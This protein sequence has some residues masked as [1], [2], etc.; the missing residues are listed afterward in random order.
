MAQTVC[1]DT[2]IVIWGILGE[3]KAEDELKREKAVHL[4]EML[5]QRDDRVLL[6][7][8]VLAEVVAKVSPPD[9]EEVV[10]K[11]S[12]AC[13]IVPFDAGSAL[14]FGT[15]RAVGMKKKSREF[16]RKEI[17]LD[18]LIVAICRRQAVQVLYTDDG[19]L[20]KLAAH[21]M[22]VEGLPPVPPKPLSLLNVQRSSG[23]FGAM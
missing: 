21:F 23:S 4:L 1:L 20:E 11:L 15:V 6:P 14:E 8:I 7:A 19:K 2:N 5:Q 22:R 18:S 16:P 9:R 13:E 3:G 17:S 10:S 12:S